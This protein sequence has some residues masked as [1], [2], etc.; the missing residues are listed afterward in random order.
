M[1]ES[2]RT[3]DNA[4]AVIVEALNSSDFIESVGAAE[5]Q[6]GADTIADLLVTGRLPA[7]PTIMFKIRMVLS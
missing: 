1:T 4:V 3:P 6:S 7:D 5:S 2:A